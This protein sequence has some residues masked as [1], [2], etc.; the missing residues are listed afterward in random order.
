MGLDSVYRDL[1]SICLTPCS[2]LCSIV[3]LKAFQSNLIYFSTANFCLSFLS[4]SVV[5]Q[6]LCIQRLANVRLTPS[7][8]FLCFVN[9][10]SMLPYPNLF[11]LLL[12]FDVD[13][14]QYVVAE[15]LCVQ[16]LPRA[17]LMASCGF[18]CFVNLK[19]ILTNSKSIF[20]LLIFF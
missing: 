5:V 15:V 18:P 9:F 19:S 11:F 13:I 6:V 17:P 20:L 4:C 16:G 10:K 12:I 3:I 2:F 14:L 1:L 8:S 7:S